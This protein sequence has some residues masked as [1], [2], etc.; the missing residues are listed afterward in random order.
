[1]QTGRR[2][3]QCELSL[4]DTA[5]LMAGML[6]AACYF[7]G[8]DA[9]AE[10]RALADALYRRVDWRWAQNGTATVSQG[11]KPECGFFTTAGRAITRRRSSMS[12]ASVRRPSRSR[13]TAFKTWGLTYQW[14]N[15][16]DSDV[17]YSGPLFTHLFSHAWID[18]RGIRDAFMR[19]KRSDYFENTR[20][21]DRHPSRI[22]RAQSA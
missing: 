21:R 18:F 19:E 6:T 11:W 12:S 13:P 3:W 14:E 1:M 20:A 22:R 8:G 7:D 4:V 16:I 10:I 15:L 5:L 9:E 17:L 2:V